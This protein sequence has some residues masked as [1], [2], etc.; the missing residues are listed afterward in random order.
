M[1][2]GPRSRVPT[3]IRFPFFGKVQG[4]V[5][6]ASAH[7]ISRL[8]RRVLRRQR[9]VAMHTLV[10]LDPKSIE[11]STIIGISLFAASSIA[12]QG[13]VVAQGSLSGTK[14]GVAQAAIV[15]PKLRISLAAEKSSHQVGLRQGDD[16]GPVVAAR[17]A[18]RLSEFTL[19]MLS[20]DNGL[21]R[22][23][24]Q[25]PADTVIS[26]STSAID[27]GLRVAT[28][29]P[30]R[31]YG[32]A[33]TEG[34]SL[35]S[36][37]LQTANRAHPQPTRV[38][39]TGAASSLGHEVRRDLGKVITFSPPKVTRTAAAMAG[40]GSHLR[41]DIVRKVHFQDDTP[42]RCL[43]SELMNVIYDVAENF[44]EVQI[45][46]TFRDPERNRRVGGAPRSF[47]LRCQAIDFRVM[48]SHRD[49]G[50]LEYLEAR[51]DV[52]GLKR[53]PLGFYHIDTGSRRTW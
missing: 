13:F 48:G 43:P 47:H 25:V 10:H 9:I 45:L 21:P 36:R 18:D 42:D 41:R 12:L 19:G 20:E 7:N 14:I 49:N 39:F 46:S 5:R 8:A 27:L 34:L 2:L 17:R 30:T 1:K 40:H 44:G 16:T 28:F 51:A 52:G 53:Y 50:L 11:R 3:D 32:R 33:N 24:S 23:A 15:P 22:I 4:N 38:A 26:K 6:Q 35:S 31:I 29:A 37:R